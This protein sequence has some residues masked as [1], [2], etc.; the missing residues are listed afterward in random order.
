VYIYS[1]YVERPGYPDRDRWGQPGDWTRAIYTSQSRFNPTCISYIQFVSNARVTLT[2]VG[3][4]NP[5]TGQARYTRRHPGLTGR[6]HP[7]TL[8]V[9]RPGW[10]YRIGRA[11]PGAG[12]GWVQPGHMR[13]YIYIYIYI[14]VRP[15]LPLPKRVLTPALTLPARVTPTSPV[16]VTR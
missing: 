10:P 3:G 6:V 1:L 8:R 11:N 13:I 9:R 4:D 15:G 5:G 2:G 12:H 14:Y 7:Y 16:G